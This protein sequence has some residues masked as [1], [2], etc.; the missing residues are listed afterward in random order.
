MPKSLLST[1]NLLHIQAHFK[2]AL[3]VSMFQ[4]FVLFLQIAGVT[5]TCTYVQEHSVVDPS[6]KTFELKSTNV[7]SSEHKH[8]MS[9]FLLLT[10]ALTASPFGSLSWCI[11]FWTFIL[12]P[13]IY[14]QVSNV[15]FFL[16]VQLSVRSTSHWEEI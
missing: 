1:C 15:I 14:V 2:D 16:L 7:S 10:V 9:G 8:F 3:S 12:C 4:S 13:R 11:Q 6:E 5:K